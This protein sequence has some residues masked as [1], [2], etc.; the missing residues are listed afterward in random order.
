MIGKQFYFIDMKSQTVK[1]GTI[2]TQ[3]IQKEGYI[4]S[5]IFDGKDKYN[6]ESNLIF[7]QEQ[8]AIDAL[9]RFIP[10]KKTMEELNNKCTE[11]L[12]TL[13]KQIIGEPEVKDV[14]NLLY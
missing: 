8:D 9:A 1:L 2:I 12:N 3:T 11:Q 7:T 5:I 10:I 4:V 13:R 14:A 6:V